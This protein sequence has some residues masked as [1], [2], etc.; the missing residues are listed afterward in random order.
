M[1]FDEIKS[2]VIDEDKD[3][4]Y[5]SSVSQ[6]DDSRTGSLYIYYLR[7]N[8]ASSKE[9]KNIIEIIN[10]VSNIIESEQKNNLFNGIG[11]YLSIE[12]FQD[13]FLKV[14]LKNYVTKLDK[15]V[16]VI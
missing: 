13:K 10:E 14:D 7:S 11:N 2:K 16:V 3:I 15:Y 8:V 12:N 9:G 4:L 5:I 6:L 1:T